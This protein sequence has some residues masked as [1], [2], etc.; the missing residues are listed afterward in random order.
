[1]NEST[2]CCVKCER[3]SAEVPLLQLHYQGHDYWICPQDLPILIHR[4]WLISEI[5]GEWTKKSTAE[6]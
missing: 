3:T 6:E 4:P 5:A 2:E 1:M